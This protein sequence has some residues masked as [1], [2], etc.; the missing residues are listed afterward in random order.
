MADVTALLEEKYP[1]Q[2]HPRAWFGH[3]VRITVK[4]REPGISGEVREEVVS[5]S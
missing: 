5:A 3:P 4:G 2:Q 1:P